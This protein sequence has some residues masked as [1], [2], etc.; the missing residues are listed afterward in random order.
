MAN[1]ELTR[2]SLLDAKDEI[3]ELIQLLLEGDET[4]GKLK[5]TALLNRVTTLNTAIQA[6]SD[7]HTLT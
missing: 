1:L 4:N 2:Q 6:S 7:F 3:F 5:S